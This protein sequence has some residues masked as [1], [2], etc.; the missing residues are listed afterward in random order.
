MAEIGVCAFLG[1]V[2]LKTVI[3]PISEYTFVFKSGG[4]SSIKYLS[5]TTIEDR[6]FFGCSSLRNVVIPDNVFYYTRV[7]ESTTSIRRK[8]NIF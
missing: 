6:A 2:S 7:F 5:E 1:C 8:K 3:F 4:G